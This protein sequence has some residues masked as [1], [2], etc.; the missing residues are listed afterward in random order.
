MNVVFMI[1][2]AVEHQSEH[3][4]SVAA[5][6]ESATN[7]GEFTITASSTTGLFE[8]LSLK[9]LNTQK[10]DVEMDFKLN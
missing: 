2:S 9:Y 10:Y 7:S 6:T 4:T 1:A 3:S 5:P 8:F